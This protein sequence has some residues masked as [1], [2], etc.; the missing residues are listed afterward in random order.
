[1]SLPQTHCHPAHLRSCA[2]LAVQHHL[3]DG[4]VDV[5]QAAG[6]GA[7]CGW[8]GTQLVVRGEL[9]K[10]CSLTCMRAGQSRAS[11]VP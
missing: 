4:E 1:M 8:M 2:N 5:D 10:Q 11:M 7:A 3:E 6:Q 9:A